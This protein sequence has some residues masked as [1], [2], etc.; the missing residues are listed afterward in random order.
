MY[1]L[2][3]DENTINIEQDLREYGLQPLEIKL[4]QLHQPK[5][6]GH[7]NFIIT[8]DSADHITLRMLQSVKYVCHSVVRWNHYSPPKKDTLQC[9]NCTRIGHLTH[10]CHM[11]PVCMFCAKKHLY[12]ACPLIKQKEPC[13]E[14]STQPSIVPAQ[15]EPLTST[16]KQE[17]KRTTTQNQRRRSIQPQGARSSKSP[18]KSAQKQL[19]PDQPPHPRR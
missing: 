13:A 5:F 19:E 9:K 17:A 2:N 14:V 10:G 18:Q 15:H 16:E 11:D 7:A 12:T 6:E 4:M 3:A 1:G 8:F